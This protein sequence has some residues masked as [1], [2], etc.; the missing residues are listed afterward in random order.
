MTRI[1]NFRA[2]SIEDRNN[3]KVT[4][5]IKEE[6]NDSSFV[7]ELPFFI[8]GE[9]GILNELANMI[10]TA[11]ETIVITAPKIDDVLKQE[12][13][14]ASQSNVRIYVLLESDGFDAWVRKG[15]SEMADILLCRMSSNALPSML[16]VDAQSPSA[17]GMLMQQS[18]PVDRALRV[19]GL[20]WGLGL[21]NEQIKILAHYAS[22][23][24]WS[25]SGA[26]KETRAASH[27]KAPQDVE[28]IKAD[29]IPLP[30]NTAVSLSLS[31]NSLVLDGFSDIKN[32]ITAGFNA[33]DLRELFEVQI[34]N[35]S[36]ISILTEPGSVESGNVVADK[37]AIS[38]VTILCSSH[39]FG[40][41]FDWIP[42][43]KLQST[44]QV[45]LRLD[46]KQTK[47]LANL[48]ERVLQNPDWSLRR[49]ISLSE[50]DENTTVRL[51]DGATETF[52]VESETVDLGIQ[53][54]T[55]W[56][57]QRLESFKPH[58]SKLPKVA[59]LTKSVNWL[60][61]NAPPN[62]PKKAVLSLIERQFG[63]FIKEATKNTSYLLNRLETHGKKGK[64]TANTL[65]KAEPEN[66]EQ[67]RDAKILRNWCEAMKDASTI[68]HSLENKED[69]DIERS[70][71]TTTIQHPTPPDSDRPKVGRLYTFEKTQYLA[72]DSWDEFDEAD[73]LAKELNAELVA[74]RD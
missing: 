50:L 58:P 56:S 19:P 2:N 10:Q 21:N 5:W 22:W 14:L 53:T 6:T 9:N 57:K 30:E 41:L 40:W 7:P 39:S 37:F 44:H 47:S 23:L 70:N 28:Q 15:D 35:R 45:A 13:I 71:K 69:S 55:P 72:I 74:E 24:F 60:W 65:E 18:T 32:Y 66:P 3:E 36:K 25:V 26:R 33:Y 17:Q 12:L 4:V 67:I 34:Q 59:P 51:E 8:S 62:P 42:D 38:L 68:L 43:A 29:L 54:V 48:I 49:D 73:K 63:T 46:K 61:T 1:Q 20:A 64:S 16:L 11:K 31:E 52:V 27:L